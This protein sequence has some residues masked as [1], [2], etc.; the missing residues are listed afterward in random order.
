MELWS[1]SRLEFEDLH[2]SD[3][4]FDVLC[5]L[6]MNSAKAVLEIILRGVGLGV[7]GRQRFFLSGG[8]LLHNNVKFVLRDE[9]IQ[10]RWEQLVFSFIMGLGVC[11][12]PHVLGME[13][14]KKLPPPAPDDNFF[15]SPSLLCVS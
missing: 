1:N 10:V 6:A 9:D 14:S 8:F 3:L 2:S 11:A 13:K 5:D 15:N 12:F 7:G 4:E